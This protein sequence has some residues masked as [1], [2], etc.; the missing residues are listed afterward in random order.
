MIAGGELIGFTM[1]NNIAG[2]I[3]LVKHFLKE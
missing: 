3:F 1:K 2:F